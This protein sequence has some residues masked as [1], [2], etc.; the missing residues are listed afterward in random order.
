MSLRILVAIAVCVVGSS[1]CVAQQASVPLAKP[2][3]WYWHIWTDK[4]GESHLTHC[5]ITRFDLKSMAAPAQP[6]FQ[7][8]QA[9]SNAQVI[10]TTQPANWKGTWHEDP[11]VQWV[12]PMQGTWFIEA[13]DGKRVNLGPGDVLLGEDQNTKTD[14]KGHKGHLSGNVGSGPVNLMVVQLAVKPTIDEA[15]HIR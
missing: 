5:R 14:A 6:Q 11:K 9:A 12:I 13:M 8:R 1:L 4:H 3:L 7:A 10:F 15:C 2:N